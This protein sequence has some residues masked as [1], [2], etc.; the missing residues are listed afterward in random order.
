MASESGGASAAGS[1]PVSVHLAQGATVRL[2]TAEEQDDLFDEA[3]VQ[4]LFRVGLAVPAAVDA[5]PGSPM[6][7]LV[8]DGDARFLVGAYDLGPERGLEVVARGVHRAIDAALRD[9]R[10]RAAEEVEAD[11]TPSPLIEYDPPDGEAEVAIEMEDVPASLTDLLDRVDEGR[12]VVLT[13][14]GKRVAVVVSWRW[15]SLQRERLAC[16]SAAYWK[17]WRT[18]TFDATGYAL[19]VLAAR[20]PSDGPDPSHRADS[21]EGGADH[22]DSH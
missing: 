22:G 5:R 8:L 9:H 6:P 3:L 20:A 17:A 7:R 4:A 15:Y 21:S 14:R 19:E 18:G 12:H 13:E 1:V 2:Q 11:P 10:Q 16:A